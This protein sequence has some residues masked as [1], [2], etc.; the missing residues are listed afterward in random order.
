MKLVF[1]IC[2]VQAHVD[3]PFTVHKVNRLLL[4]QNKSIRLLLTRSL[5]TTSHLV[6]FIVEHFSEKK[7]SLASFNH[8]DKDDDVIA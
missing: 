2:S 1:V 7:N 4:K 8:D 5:S 6:F 3:T